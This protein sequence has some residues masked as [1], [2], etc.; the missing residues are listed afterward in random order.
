VKGWSAL[1]GSFPKIG[2]H[3]GTTRQGKSDSGI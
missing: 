1:G 3:E 2:G